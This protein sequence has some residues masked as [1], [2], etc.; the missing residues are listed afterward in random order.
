MPKDD[1][2]MV[3]DGARLMFETLEAGAAPDAPLRVEAEH[4]VLVRVVAGLVCLTVGGD[5]RLL[6]VGEEAVVPAGAPHRLAS[7]GGQARL[8]SGLR[9][10]RG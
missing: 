10:A 5:A 1:V 2:A 4:D 9:P 6:A 8:V 7:A 3:I